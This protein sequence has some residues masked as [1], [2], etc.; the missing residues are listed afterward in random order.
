MDSEWHFILPSCVF[1]SF[2]FLHSHVRAKDLDQKLRHHHDLQKMWPGKVFGFECLQVQDVF[3]TPPNCVP[4]RD[5]FLTPSVLKELN[6]TAFT[7]WLVKGGKQEEELKN[8][9]PIDI[10][11]FFIKRPFNYSE[12]EIQNKTTLIP[13][14]GFLPGLN[15]RIYSNLF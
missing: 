13:N 15:R 4:N 1:L 7:S 9:W 8:R 6:P 3:P 14:F 5:L 10:I 2:K 12:I 11:G